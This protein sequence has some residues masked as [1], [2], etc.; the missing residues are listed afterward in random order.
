MVGK[1]VQPLN[2]N[3][4]G[5]EQKFPSSSNKAIPISGYDGYAFPPPF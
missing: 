5:I 2:K 3:K 1:K 4:T